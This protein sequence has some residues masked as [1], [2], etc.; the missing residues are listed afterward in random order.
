MTGL[1]GVVVVAGIDLH[2]DDRD[3]LADLFAAIR[4]GAAVGAAVQVDPD[5]RR[6]I[7][8]PAAI[9]PPRPELPSR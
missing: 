9:P 1:I 4:E 5:Q 2:D 3:H 8:Q 7:D 6:R